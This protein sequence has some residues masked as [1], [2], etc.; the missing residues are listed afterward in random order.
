MLTIV[1]QGGLCNTMF[2]WALG[3]AFE[4]RGH[5]VQYDTARLDHDPGRRY[6]L[7]QLGLKLKL[8]SGAQTGRLVQEGSMRYNPNIF[9]VEDPSTL[10]GYWQCEKYFADIAARIRKSLWAPTHVAPKLSDQSVSVGNEIMNCG[11]SCFV[12]VRRSDN[13]RPA[14]VAVHGLLSD[15]FYYLRAMTEMRTCV[16]D[17]H[18]FLFS[19]D[20]EWCHEHFSMCHGLMVVGHNAPSFTVDAK[21]DIHWKPGGREVEDLWLMSLCRH[22][23]IGNSSFSWWSAWL[24]DTQSDRI[25][26]CP[27]RWFNS[28]QLDATDICPQRWRRIPIR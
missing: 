2:Q 23:V 20:P 7:D 28:T 22:A 27:D 21:H 5:T 1:L 17:A 8:S 24:G 18:F 4:A 12:H 6:M 9:E 19:D 16:P 14:G 26:L 25:V 3:Q 10:I 15:S 11:T 13:L